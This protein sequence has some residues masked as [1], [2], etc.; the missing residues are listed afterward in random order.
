[1]TVSITFTW[2][3]YDMITSIDDSKYII[4]M[5]YL[6][7]DKLPIEDGKYNFYMVYLGHDNF[8]M[9]YLGHDHFSYRTVG[10]TFT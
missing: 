8:Y 4:Y 6:G 7:H 2:F 3:T 1:M 9:V 10:I 5:V